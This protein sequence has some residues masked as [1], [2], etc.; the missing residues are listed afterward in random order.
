MGAKYQ[1]ANILFF[2]PLWF[3]NRLARVSFAAGRQHG[4]LDVCLRREDRLHR[5]G[6]RA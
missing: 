1:T 2:A 3:P 4:M 6:V 5:A